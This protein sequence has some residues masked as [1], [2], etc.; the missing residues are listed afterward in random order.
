[1]MAGS[2]SRAA[3]QIVANDDSSPTDKCIEARKESTMMPAGASLRPARELGPRELGP[4]GR[5]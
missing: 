4:G 3:L 1:M 2:S 5:C